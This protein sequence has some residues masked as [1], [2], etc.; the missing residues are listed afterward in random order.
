MAVKERT[1]AKNHIIN[2]NGRL[3][4][5]S[6]GDTI[7]ADLAKRLGLGEHLF[8]DGDDP[9][10]EA[11]A[12]MAVSG[13]NSND[14]FAGAQPARTGLGSLSPQELKNYARDNGI[15]IGDA[16]RKPDLLAVIAK[17]EAD[18]DGASQK[19]ADDAAL[20]EKADQNDE[21]KA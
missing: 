5:K 7:D 17:A 16:S 6:P 21:D 1:F 18:R 12:E 11:L 15:A 3:V 19:S 9:R 2:A 8:D 10:N 4:R 13:G 20:N 14:H